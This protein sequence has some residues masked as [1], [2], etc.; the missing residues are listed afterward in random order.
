[1]SRE[2]I[3]MH[4]EMKK[5]KKNQKHFFQHV[6][7]NS[8]FPLLLYEL[9]TKIMYTYFWRSLYNT[10]AHHD[11]YKKNRKK[12]SILSAISFQTIVLHYYSV[13]EEI[14]T[15]LFSLNYLC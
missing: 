1:M 14:K 8:L 5:D 2:F 11:L 12:K 9:L 13:E 3:K 6:C 15:A 7:T 4:E 10:R